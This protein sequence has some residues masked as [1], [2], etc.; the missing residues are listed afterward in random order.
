MV[1]IKKLQSYLLLVTSS[2][3]SLKFSKV[4]AIP[5]M[6]DTDHKIKMTGQFSSKRVQFNKSQHKY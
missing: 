2:L 1:E 5:L 6:L 4:T 3:C